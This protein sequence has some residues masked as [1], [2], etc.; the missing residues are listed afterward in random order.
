MTTN[1][2]SSMFSGIGEQ[3]NKLKE[4]GSNFA[5]S[6]SEQ[7]NKISENSSNMLNSVKEQVADTQ[8]NVNEKLNEFSNTANAGITGTTT[9]SFADSNGIIAKFGFFI[10]VIIFFLLA[11]N[12]GIRLISY[13][14]KPSS[15]IF[16]IDGMIDGFNK[17]IITQSGADIKSLIRRSNNEKTGIEFTWAVW[18]SLNGFQTGN[19]VNNNQCVFVKGDGKISNAPGVYFTDSSNVLK[20]V[21]DTNAKTPSDIVIPNIPIN[22]WFHLTIRCQNKYLDVYINGLIV[23]R[24]NLENVPVQNYDDVIVCNDGGFTGK[25]SNLIYFNYSLNAVDINGLVNEGPNLK[26]VNNNA[27][28]SY[29]SQN[30]LSNLW[31]S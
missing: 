28:Q 15:K 10:L 24:K 22:K 13:F 25:L 14:M 17:K 31:Y 23:Y 19:L 7:T 4:S 12:L 18:L 3:F 5:N 9:T 27:N 6:L 2:N 29:G 16:L 21:M 30:Y 26:N 8:K 11:L 1:Q 20:I